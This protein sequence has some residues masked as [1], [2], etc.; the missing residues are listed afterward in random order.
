MFAPVFGKEISGPA[1]VIDWLDPR[2]RQIL[3]NLK[4]KHIGPQRAA[5]QIQ[6]LTG[7]EVSHT[8][9]RVKCRIL[10]ELVSG[11]LHPCCR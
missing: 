11:L 5:Y 9:L 7:E 8:T 3:R 2:V 6:K 10:D 1:A 4:D